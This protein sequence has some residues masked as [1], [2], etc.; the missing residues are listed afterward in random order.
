MVTIEKNPIVSE[1]RKY[2][3]ISEKL[4]FLVLLILLAIHSHTLL[5]Y[6]V[7]AKSIRTAEIFIKKAL[8][9]EDKYSFIGSK[10]SRLYVSQ[11]YYKKKNNLNILS[12]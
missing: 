3:I 4:C 6:T 9:I 10:C 2:P 7:S 8:F 1:K 12:P 11:H 5:P